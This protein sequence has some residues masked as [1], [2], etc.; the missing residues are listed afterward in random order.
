M[1]QEK[2]KDEGTRAQAYDTA[3]FLCYRWHGGGNTTRPTFERTCTT[4]PHSRVPRGGSLCSELL[5]RTGGLIQAMH[6]RYRQP[7]TVVELGFCNSNRYPGC[8]ISRPACHSRHVITASSPFG[9]ATGPKTDAFG[10]V[11]CHIPAQP[12]RTA[13]HRDPDCWRPRMKR[14]RRRLFLHGEEPVPWLRNYVPCR[15]HLGQGLAG[16]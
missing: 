2:E 8:C 14:C 13:P 11:P 7:G 16:V 6:V 5:P 12:R 9:R 3:R 10:S 15:P 1:C 4:R